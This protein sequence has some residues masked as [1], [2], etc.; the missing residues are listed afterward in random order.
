MSDQGTPFPAKALLRQLSD[1][2]RAT[3]VDH[4]PGEAGGTVAL[5]RALRDAGVL[6][7]TGRTAKLTPLG[8]QVLRL[9]KVFAP[10]VR[11]A[12]VAR[13]R[14]PAKRPQ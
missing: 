1:A 12:R 14:R 13:Q 8:R 9:A 4:R 11:S 7:G 6:D 10:R 5:R 2:Q 3:I